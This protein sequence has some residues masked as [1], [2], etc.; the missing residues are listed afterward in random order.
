MLKQY[1]VVDL[2]MTGVHAKSDSIIEIG[3]VKVSEDAEGQVKTET[4]QSLV[5]PRTPISPE[6]ENLTGISNAMVENALDLDMAMEKFLAFSGE[7]PLVGHMISCDFSFLKQWAVNH[8]RSFERLGVDT[9]KISRACLPELPSHKLGDVA[10]YY[11]IEAGI[12]HRALE[13]ALMTNIL[14]RTLATEFEE[15]MASLFVPRTLRY[16]AKRQTPVTAQQIRF[17]KRFCEYY[18]LELPAGLESFTRSEA[19]RVTDKMIERYG[20]LPKEG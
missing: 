6:I 2:E 12:S 7:L 3:A 16:Q 11:G 19:S 14:Y 8:K 15:E 10:E 18:H 17:L 9:L 1:V 4:F 13:D 5:K 20:R